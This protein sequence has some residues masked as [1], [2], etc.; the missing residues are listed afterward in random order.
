MHVV[1]LISDG[2]CGNKKKGQRSGRWL[3]VTVTLPV[4][5]C[6]G[7]N[8]FIPKGGYTLVTL[9]RTVLQVTD[10]IRSYV[11]N[12]NRVPHGVIVSCER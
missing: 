3:R 11:L 10:T 9:P 1:S 12:F 7:R 5:I 4:H 8:C 2:A 6:S